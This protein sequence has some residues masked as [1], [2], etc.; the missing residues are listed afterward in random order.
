MDFEQYAYSQKESIL[1]TLEEFVR[2]PAP[3]FHEHARAE[4]CLNWLK[5][6]GIPA[7]M[8]EI[9]N[10]TA[11]FRLRPGAAN[12]ML[13]AHSDTVFP[14]DTPLEI[15]RAGSLWRCPGIGDDTANV[16]LLLHLAEYVFIEKPPAC[17]GLI[18]AV[19][20]CEEG[21]GNL[22]GCRKLIE[23][24][25][26][27]YGVPAPDEKTVEANLS[28]SDG[29]AGL[30]DDHPLVAVSPSGQNAESSDDH[31][32]TTR[33]SSGRNAEPFI[34]STPS[35]GSVI[36]FDLYR[37]KV[38]TD[39]IGSVRYRITVKA[40]GGHSYLDFGNTNA[41]AVLSEIITKLYSY[42]PEPGTTFNVGTIE[43][44]TTVNT[45]A[46]EAS[47]LFEFRS[48]K[49]GSLDEAEAFL[50][51]VLA[52]YQPFEANLPEGRTVTVFCETVGRR[53]CSGNVPAEPMSR[54]ADICSRAVELTTGNLPQRASASTD[55]NI[56][57]SMGIPAACVGLIIGG[58][59]HTR[60]E[61][62]DASSL[63][64][65][66]AI[67]L[68]VLEG[69]FPCIQ[70]QWHIADPDLSES[71]GRQ[72]KAAHEPLPALP[73]RK[74]HGT[75]GLFETEK[76]EILDILR[77]CDADFCP[78]LSARGG[79]SEQQLFG[80]AA[81]SDGV[82]DYFQDILKQE[83]LFWERDGKII[84]FMSFRPSYTCEALK[85][86]GDTVYLTTL[87]IRREFRG[88]GLSVPIY[89]AVLDYIREAY[90]GKHVAYRTWSGNAA[91][92]HTARRLCFKEAARIKDDRGP[93]EDTV[94]FIC[95]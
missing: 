40:Q 41:I 45:I 43:G 10:V 19:N 65:G 85:D 76:E 1:K 87:C 7:E 12:I 29:N 39:C 4:Y 8:D 90:P 9:G 21:L 69:L 11:C 27:V 78:P 28:P 50:Q 60:E 38:F 81:R 5:T 15:S 24:F 47:M 70:D 42:R 91:Q 53:P 30:S 92:M 46:A 83:T 6:R 79:T 62:V 95:F 23:R 44:G 58:G 2:I 71:T 88:Q 37:D 59:A 73:R 14:E 33:L 34:V 16:V 77:E 75:E 63:T 25:S 82:L 89:R 68:R 55:C 18:F 13:M 49:A 80:E 17:E 61:W 35:L 67:A 54:L 84:A 93:G 56:P 22:A 51:S 36:S 64:D 31:P 32:V 20:V 66:L 52:E 48:Q 74:S 86:Y 57:L 72:P 3:S 26:P 94:Y